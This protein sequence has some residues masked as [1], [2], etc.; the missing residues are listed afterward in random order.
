[1][2]SVVSIVVYCMIKKTLFEKHNV[3]SSS[4]M[5]LSCSSFLSKFDLEQPMESSAN[6]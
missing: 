1:M 6:M 4:N 5:H 2:G 3:I